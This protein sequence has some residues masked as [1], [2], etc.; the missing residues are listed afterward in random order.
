MH[1]AALRLVRAVI[2]EQYVQAKRGSREN[3]VRPLFLLSE[4]CSALRIIIITLVALISAIT[5][6][7]FKTRIAFWDNVETSQLARVA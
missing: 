4:N 7:K 5:H 2:E 6:H 1:F 3:D